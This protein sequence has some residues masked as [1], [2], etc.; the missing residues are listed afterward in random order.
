MERYVVSAGKYLSN[1][2]GST[3]VRNVGNSTQM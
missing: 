1:L 2:E 3:V